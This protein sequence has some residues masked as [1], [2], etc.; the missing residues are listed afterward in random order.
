M[1]LSMTSGSESCLSRGGALSCLQNIPFPCPN[2][3]WLGAGWVLQGS[4]TPFGSA[5]GWGAAQK[6]SLGSKGK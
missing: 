4:T 3:A 6:C 2:A 1:L 5:C